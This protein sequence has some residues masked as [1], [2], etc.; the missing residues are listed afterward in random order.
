MDFLQRDRIFHS[1]AR[2]PYSE[3]LIHFLT[4]RRPLCRIA[5]QSVLE[6]PAHEGEESS[7]GDQRP[8][9]HQRAGQVA[10]KREQALP[11]KT[12]AV[13]DQA[14]TRVAE[15]ISRA[16]AYRE[17]GNYAGALAELR[18]AQALD[19]GNE[20]IRR[21]IDQTRRACNAEKVLGNPVDCS[22]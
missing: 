8:E 10:P 16:Q 2:E 17:Q 5:R 7:D 14:I 13:S 15:H 1:N 9:G 11:R 22:P 21:E 20:S 4:Q 6:E 3:Q 19:A 12:E 18:R